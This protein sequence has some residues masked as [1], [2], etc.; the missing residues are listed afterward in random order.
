MNIRTLEQVG[1]LDRRKQFL[2]E[3]LL[4][5]GKVCAA[6]GRNRGAISLLLQKIGYSIVM[7]KANFSGLKLTPK[8][9]SVCFM[10][11]DRA[12]R[13]ADESL[14]NVMKDNLH[15]ENSCSLYGHESIFRKNIEHD[16]KSI[17]ADVIIVDQGRN[18]SKG[19]GS[20]SQ[21]LAGFLRP[22]KRYAART[23]SCIL[24][25]QR[26][27]MKNFDSP[28]T[29]ISFKGRNGEMNRALISEL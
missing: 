26:N 5:K 29:K 12:T 14:F 2:L 9:S 4:P 15:P 10:S 23:G 19:N 28:I 16:L 1:Y 18:L 7:K 11:T 17:R 21:K 6:V 22:F 24:F 20:S 27:S 13:G 25:I 8:H 3:N